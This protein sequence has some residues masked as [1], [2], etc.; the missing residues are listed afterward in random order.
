[1]KVQNGNFQIVKVQK[2]T[3]IM[4]LHHYPPIHSQISHL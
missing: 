2:E 1:M 4:I 3:E